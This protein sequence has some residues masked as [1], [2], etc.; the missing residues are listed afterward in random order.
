MGMAEGIE[1]VPV[2]GCRCDHR[3]AVRYRGPVAHP[4]FATCRLETRKEHSC[5]GHHGVDT[6]PVRRQ[7]QAAKLNRPPDPQADGQGRE[8]ETVTRKHDHAI[9][10]D[11]G[12]RNRDVVAAFRIKRYGITQLRRQMLRPGA[13][14]YNKMDRLDPLSGFCHEIATRL[15]GLKICNLSHLKS[16]TLISEPVRK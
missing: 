1:N 9:D 5:L 7:F 12:F 10:R 3:K 8:N 6:L 4:A 13:A 2:P 15:A 14:G 11:P 16:A